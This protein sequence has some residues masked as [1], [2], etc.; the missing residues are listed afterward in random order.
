MNSTNDAR[1]DAGTERTAL[2]DVLAE[3]D[4]EELLQVSH[5][6]YCG[7][8]GCFGGGDCMKVDAG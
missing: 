6:G 1:N 5:C 8:G 3:K 2:L 4:R 7:C